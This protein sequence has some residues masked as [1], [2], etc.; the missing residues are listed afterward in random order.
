MVLTEEG[1]S[2]TA[3]DRKGNDMENLYTI[4]EAAKKTRMSQAW[5]RMKVYQKKLRF[6]R[7]GRRVLIPESTITSLLAESV[8]DLR[9]S[10]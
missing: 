3:K 10:S 8:I 7:I 1:L 6:L 5:W 9:Q 4:P 2:F